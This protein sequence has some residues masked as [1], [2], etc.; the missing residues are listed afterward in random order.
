[1]AEG[2]IG[3]HMMVVV[4]VVAWEAVIDMRGV[5]HPLVPRVRVAMLRGVHCEGEIPWPHSIHRSRSRKILD[6]AVHN[7]WADFLREIV[8]IQM[9]LRVT[10]PENAFNEASYPS[11]HIS[12]RNTWRSPH[13]L[14]PVSGGY[15]L[16]TS[17]ESGVGVACCHDCRVHGLYSL[18]GETSYRKISWSLEA[19]RFGFKLFQSLWNLTGMHLGSSAAEMTVKF[20]SDTIIITSNLG[21]LRL[22]EIWQ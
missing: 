7:R 16:P 11:Q 20:Q 6:L 1:M 9:V 18:S 8:P 3:V 21:A 2:A 10:L 4:G 13:A 12:R 19:T 22:H 14:D 17:G 15:C 5:G